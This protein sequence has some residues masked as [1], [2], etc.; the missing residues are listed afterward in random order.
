MTFPRAAGPLRIASYNVHRTIGADGR[1]D[2]A[3]IAAVVA[4]L[5]ADVVALQEVE[6]DPCG[7]EPAGDLR[8]L[9]RATGLAAVFGATV[10]RADASYGNALLT[11]HPVLAVRRLDLSR[12]GREARGALDVDLDVGGSS[13]RVIATHLGLRPSERLAQVALLLAAVG[14]HAGPT[15]V[16]GDFNDWWPRARSVRELAARFGGG[17]RLATFPAR[18]PLLALDRIWVQ[19]RGAAVHATVHRSPL[20]RVA[21]DHLPVVATVGETRPARP[22]S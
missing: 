20:A 9:E 13:V 11:R 4:E 14:D 3:R 18:R 10:V 15:I 21:S 17:A 1:R 2:P 22:T 16:V 7:G 12:P 5:G 6:V 19:P 8:L